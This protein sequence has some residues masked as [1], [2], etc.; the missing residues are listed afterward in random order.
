MD[1][2]YQ[3]FISSTYM[4]LVEERREVIQALLEMDCVPAGMEMFP[5][6]NDD[7][8]TLI[9]QV[10][11]ESDYYVVIV[12]GRYGSMAP[13]GISYTEKEYDYAVSTGKPVLGF[14]HANPGQLPLNKSQ[15]AAQAELDAFTAKV[16]SRLV[17]SYGSPAEL[18]SAV[19]RSLIMTMKKNPAEGWV[20]GQF[21]MT[22]EVQAEMAELRAKLS[23]M[24]LQ[25]STKSSAII[26]PDL[27]SG[28]DVY[29]MEVVLEYKTS[30]EIRREETSYDLAPIRIANTNVPASWNDIFGELG[31]RMFDEIN[32]RAMSRALGAYVQ[33]LLLGSRNDLLPSGFA[34]AETVSISQESFDDI[35]IQLFA[36]NLITHGVKSR[37]ARDTA[38]YW[39]LSELGRETLMK[40]R[41]IKRTSSEASK[42]SQPV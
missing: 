20:R 14:V 11:D 3:V 22:P 19:S 28:E 12:G 5:A 17:K 33:R 13:D 35:A 42:V 37:D 4:D 16:K 7:Q 38:K 23:Q 1:R 34:Y 10:I 21:A 18:G 39:M 41:A 27:E 40:L 8:W 9:Q 29:P 6:A 25:A 2:R 24:E 26:P 36:L 30:H 31:P 32:E 15:P